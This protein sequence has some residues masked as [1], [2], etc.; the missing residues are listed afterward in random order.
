MVEATPPCGGDPGP[1]SQMLTWRWCVGMGLELLWPPLGLEPLLA[2]FLW[3]CLHGWWKAYFSLHVLCWAA[4]HMSYLLKPGHRLTF[5]LIVE[6]WLNLL[7]LR[8]ANFLS[9]TLVLQELFNTVSS[10]EISNRSSGNLTPLEPA[11]SSQS[12]H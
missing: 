9:S 5:P 12:W 4:H 6:H 11:L 10:F 1:P 7:Q 2:S 3:L 8:N